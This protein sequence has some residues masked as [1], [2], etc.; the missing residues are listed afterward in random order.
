MLDMVKRALRITTNDFDSLLTIYIN[1]CIAEMSGVGVTNISQTEGSVT[2]YDP[3]A[4]SAI[5]AYCK[6]KFGNNEDKADFEHIYKDKVEILKV[7]TGH[8][9][10]EA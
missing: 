1:D 8:T 4:Q 3:Q 2:T 7:M 9:D 5:I 10:W 6:W